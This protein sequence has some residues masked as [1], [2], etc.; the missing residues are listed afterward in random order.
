ME[1]I[2]GTS[3]ASSIVHLTSPPTVCRKVGP[4][5]AADMPLSLS[6]LHVLGD[7]RIAFVACEEDHLSVPFALTWH[8]VRRIKRHEEL[9]FDYGH[10]TA[11]RSDIG[12]DRLAGN[13]STR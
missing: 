10:V 13:T 9:T 5:I 2:T 11:Y 1:R 12:A 4:F 7:H 8:P 6:V 3:L